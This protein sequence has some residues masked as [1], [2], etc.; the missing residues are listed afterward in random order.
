MNMMTQGNG[1]V[2][3]SSYYNQGGMNNA[4]QHIQVQQ[5]QQNLPLQHQHHQQ[6]VSQQQNAFQY[7]NLAMQQ[8]QYVGNKSVE[9]SGKDESKFTSPATSFGKK[10]DSQNK[11]ISEKK[12]LGLEVIISDTESSI[13]FEGP[14][15]YAMDQKAMATMASQASFL[16]NVV[17]EKPRLI[18]GGGMSQ[19]TSSSLS[20]VNHNNNNIHNNSAP[21]VALSD[22]VQVTR[23]TDQ[24][25]KEATDKMLI[26]M[27][28]IVD[29]VSIMYYERR[30]VQEQEK[31]QMNS[32][33]N[34]TVALQESNAA[35]Q[36]QQLENHQIVAKHE[37]LKKQASDNI[38]NAD[39]ISAQIVAAQLQ[40]NMY[41]GQSLHQLSYNALA[42]MEA[43][44]KEVLAKIALEKQKFQHV[45][46]I[47]PSFLDRHIYSPTSA[48]SGPH[49][50]SSAGLHPSASSTSSSS[51]SSFSSAFKTVSSGRESNSS[52][53]SK[54]SIS[55]ENKSKAHSNDK[56][57]SLQFQFMNISNSSNS[58]NL[59]SA[60]S[61]S[62]LNDFETER[63]KSYRALESFCKKCYV[64]VVATVFLPCKHQA[65]C[66]ACSKTAETCSVCTA[67]IAAVEPVYQSYA[68]STSYS[69]GSK[70]PTLPISSS[71][72]TITLYGSNS[73]AGTI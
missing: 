19:S 15:G 28:D 72:S 51:I 46:N 2:M 38:A 33:I 12:D 18:S 9:I 47:P 3:M 45:D 73:N 32:S 54:D 49:G 63:T 60:L 35:L 6:H 40:L 68:V 58:A 8:N 37:T 69:V 16:G 48:V 55:D 43:A 23:M 56:A 21:N 30:A 4:Q 13:T 31:L 17:N 71:S 57:T 25:F 64:E 1:P 52:T 61:S 62:N 14:Y 36:K 20:S 66:V 11:P 10:F 70:H 29:Q 41:E 22:S 7:Q 59:G 53:S 39:K 67:R 24:E 26:N 42:Q 50:T 34:H 27:L 44:Q 5:Q 65:L